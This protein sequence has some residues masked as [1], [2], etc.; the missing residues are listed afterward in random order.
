MSMNTEAANSG[1]LIGTGSGTGLDGRVSKTDRTQ[2]QQFILAASVFGML[3]GITWALLFRELPPQNNDIIVFLLGNITAIA[4]MIAAFYWPSSVQQAKAD[5]TIQKMAQ[6]LT[7]APPTTVTTTITSDPKPNSNEAE[8][9]PEIPAKITGESE[10]P[11]LSK[12]LPP[13]LRGYDQ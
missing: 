11:A 5:E 12:D 2:N 10:V 13:W 4:G 8:P 1:T 6:A 3:G 7:P 9:G